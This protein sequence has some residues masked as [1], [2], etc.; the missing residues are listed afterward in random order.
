MPTWYYFEKHPPVPD[1]AHFALPTGV[2]FN[3][4]FDPA[5]IEKQTV[6]TGN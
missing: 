2:G 5:K 4:E 3:V 1:N 6:I